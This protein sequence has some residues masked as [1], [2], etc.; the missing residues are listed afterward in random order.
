MRDSPWDVGNQHLFEQRDDVKRE[1]QCSRSDRVLRF[2]SYGTPVGF[3]YENGSPE[4]RTACGSSLSVFVAFITLTFF[5]NKIIVMA[6]HKGSNFSTLS[7]DNYFTYNDTFTQEDD[8]RLAF[9]LDGQVDDLELSVK[10]SYS[11]YLVGEFN[12]TTFELHTCTEEEL[13]EFY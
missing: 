5:A 6:T 3:N 1:A 4:Y 11:N 12:E 13:G 10:M 7:A 8:F 2:D 9:G